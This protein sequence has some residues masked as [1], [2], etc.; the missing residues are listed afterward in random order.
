M[1]ENEQSE[2]NELVLL[3]QKYEE[4]LS[5]DPKSNAFCQL[6]DVLCKQGKVDKATGVLIRGLSHNKNNVTARFMLGMI[7]YDR[8]LIDQAKKEMEIVLEITPD[9]IEA[10]KLLSEI[11]KSEDN[12]QKAL[13]TLEGVYV[14]HRTDSTLSDEIDQIRKLI[15]EKELEQSGRAF[16]TP[17]ESRKINH[18][19]L[20]EPL[21]DRELN[22]ETMFNLYLEQGQYDQA[23]KI[24][25]KIYQD[26]DQKKSAIEKL[27][28]TKLNKMNTS[29]GF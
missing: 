17:I 18:V 3:E 14:F 2:H 13:S 9:N 7:Y 27:E 10:A 12:L 15:S 22:T 16:E 23:R 1:C 5:S 6:A 8:W 11:F 20:E 28:K 4:I 24:I 26:E 21:I 25:D 29:A 19:R